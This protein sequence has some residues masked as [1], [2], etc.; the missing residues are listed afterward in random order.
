MCQ[1]NPCERKA[2]AATCHHHHQNLYCFWQ[3]SVKNYL[4]LLDDK[5]DGKQN[6]YLWFLKTQNL[7]FSQFFLEIRQLENKPG[8]A[9]EEN[10]LPPPRSPLELLEMTDVSLGDDVENS[11]ILK[12]HEFSFSLMVFKSQKTGWISS[13]ISC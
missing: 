4:F 8:S 6:H 1:R 5:N 13:R 12:G 7:N 11:A 9:L 10:L 2:N 3:T